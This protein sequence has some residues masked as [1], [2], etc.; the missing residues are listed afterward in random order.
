LYHSMVNGSMGACG[1]AAAAAAPLPLLLL[2]L[3]LL[4]LSRCTLSRT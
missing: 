2:L 3:L 1:V 4:L